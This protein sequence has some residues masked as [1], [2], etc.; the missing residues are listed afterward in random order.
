MVARTHKTLRDHG[1]ARPSFS[2]LASSGFL[3]CMRCRPFL[4]RTGNHTKSGRAVRV[5]RSHRRA[6]GPLGL[7]V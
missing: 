2:H 6:C 1:D 5:N 3:R 4:L 7:R